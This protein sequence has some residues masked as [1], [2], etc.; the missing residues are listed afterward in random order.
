MN[1][2]VKLC[3]FWTCN[4]NPLKGMEPMLWMNKY[5]NIVKDVKCNNGYKT[6]MMIKFLIIKKRKN[7]NKHI[8]YERCSLCQSFYEY[9]Q[10]KT[11]KLRT[12]YCEKTSVKFLGKLVIHLCKNCEQNSPASIS[13]A[14]V[15][16]ITKWKL[17]IS[18]WE[19]QNRSQ[20]LLLKNKNNSNEHSTIT[21]QTWTMINDPVL[22]LFST[23]AWNLAYW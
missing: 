22:S 15:N 23:I 16:P 10:S 17:Y 8:V 14:L 6:R 20:T 18:S 19:S 4:C 3:P 11:W 12:K 5:Q 21:N 2:N 1:G 13:K 9:F 7:D